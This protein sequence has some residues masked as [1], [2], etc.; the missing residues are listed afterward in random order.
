MSWT[1]NIHGLTE[2]EAG[3]V[4][5]ATRKMLKRNLDNWAFMEDND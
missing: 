3:R 1:L 4:L 2:E 5:A